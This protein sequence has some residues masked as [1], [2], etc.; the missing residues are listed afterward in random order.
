MAFVIQCK[1]PRAKISL[2][3]LG[4]ILLVRP[5][6]PGW[7]RIFCESVRQDTKGTRNSEHQ[8]QN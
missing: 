1:D 4:K 3:L 6:Q 8:P 7:K 5:I 2:G